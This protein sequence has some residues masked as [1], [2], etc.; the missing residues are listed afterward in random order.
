MTSGFKTRDEPRAGGAVRLE[1]T[2]P[3]PIA[4]P[5]GL[6]AHAAAVRT[7][8]GQTLALVLD[9]NEAAFAVRSGVLMLHLT[10]P[11]ELR[12]VVAILYPGDV[13]RSTFA[14]P[15]ATASLTA[16]APGEVLRAR[17]SALQGLAAEEAEVARYFEDAAARQTA[18]QAIH[19]ASIG[20]FDCQQRVATL[21]MELALRTGV[22]SP[23]GGLAFDMPLSRTDMADYLG[24]NA[25]TLSRTMS[26]LRASGLISHPE[27]HR[28]VVRDFAALAAL[29]P[30][31]P[32]LM[33]LHGAHAAKAPACTAG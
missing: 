27:R 26:R 7:R 9:G 28:A 30:A 18:R 1:V 13:L 24:L 33:A 8:R 21:L 4:I 29:S 14:P 23:C 15:N 2:T 3:A 5:A 12:Q 16:V 6:G 19:V 10:L 22:L 31:A 20:R 11:H 25:D 17:W 32:S